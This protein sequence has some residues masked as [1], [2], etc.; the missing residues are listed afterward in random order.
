LEDQACTDTEQEQQQQHQ[1]K[2]AELL[3][4]VVAG[5][6]RKDTYILVPKCAADYVVRPCILI[7][8]VVVVVVVAVEVGMDTNVEKNALDMRQ[9]VLVEEE[10]RTFD[11]T[12]QPSLDP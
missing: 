4:T 8:V 1:E 7:H 12:L 10:F 11:S 3:D 5:T 6:E 2:Q 9:Q